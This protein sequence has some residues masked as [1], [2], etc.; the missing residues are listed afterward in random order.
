M[1]L[2]TRHHDTTIPRYEWRYYIKRKFWDVKSITHQQM[3]CFR[4]IWAV[5]RHY[6]IY[7][8]N[9]IQPSCRSREG[10]NCAHFLYH[11]RQHTM[12]QQLP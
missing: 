6:N 4:R 10:I 3:K 8:S 12:K 1:I 5:I 9:I 7:N 11:Q 2:G